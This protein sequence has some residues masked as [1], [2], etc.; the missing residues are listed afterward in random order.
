MA[1]KVI[2]Y[3]TPNCSTCDVA[4]EE[5]AAEGVELEERN[6]MTRQE[7][8]DE[9]MRYSISVPIILREGKVEIGW[10]GDHGCDF[11]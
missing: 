11:V 7:W 10:K 6:I 3:T 5:L 2:L 8:F 1:D 4:R 9:A